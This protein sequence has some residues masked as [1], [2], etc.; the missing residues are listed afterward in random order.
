M[1]EYIL[2]QCYF[3]L[4]FDISSPP[5]LKNKINLNYSMFAWEEVFFRIT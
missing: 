1:K 2:L 5:P 4:N 3:H